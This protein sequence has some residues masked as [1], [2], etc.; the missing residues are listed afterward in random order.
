MDTV[1]GDVSGEAT[2]P[3][4]P[5]EDH[6]RMEIDREEQEQAQVD[7][8]LRVTPGDDIERAT[9]TPPRR[10]STEEP[11]WNTPPRGDIV[12][13][14]NPDYVP[15]SAVT[16]V[17]TQPSPLPAPPPRP[18]EGTPPSLR[19]PLPSPP[20]PPVV[21]PRTPF[22][23]IPAS[24]AK[25]KRNFEVVVEVPAKRFKPPPDQKLTTSSDTSTASTGR[26]IP[27]DVVFVPRAPIQI[28]NSQKP[29]KPKK[30]PKAPEPEIQ[31]IQKEEWVLTLPAKQP[32]RRIR[33]PS[34]KIDLNPKIRDVLV[35]RA[36]MLSHFG[37]HNIRSFAVPSRKKVHPQE[38]GHFLFINGD[39]SPQAPSAP[40]KPGLITLFEENPLP[41]RK[42]YRVFLGARGQPAN[43]ARW[44]Y[45]G[46]YKTRRL[47]AWTP[48]EI[49]Q[50]AQEIKNHWTTRIRLWAW[51]RPMVS[52]IMLR[53]ELHREPT[54][55]EVDI[56]VTQ[57]KAKVVD[58]PSS[59]IILAALENGD[60]KL[61]PWR[62][63]CDGY[64]QHLQREI[65]NTF[66][67]YQLQI[68]QKASKS[69]IE[70]L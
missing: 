47:P 65:A 4:P 46:L 68:Q 15:R 37:A 1:P 43:L 34:F 44:G 60:E 31:E 20:P 24:R 23:I 64:E 21:R 62:L 39:F 6:D 32:I 17:D 69:S 54:K 59:E 29:K 66:P 57:L 16:K 63:V 53:T 41:K 55:A 67:H 19:P 28:Q 36:Y 38:Y 27:G 3:D 61:Y 12:F 13:K 45:M 40:G 22:G 35:S 10:Q 49:R 25:R 18:H 33:A 58:A 30:A 5:G 9:G 51:A 8:L 11:L 7:R 2:D 26:S 48:E 70:I 56:R 14:V 42:H 50:H 52:R